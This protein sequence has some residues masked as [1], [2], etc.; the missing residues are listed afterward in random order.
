MRPE[1]LL[2]SIGEIDVK[3][4]TSARRRLEASGDHRSADCK[5]RVCRRT[6][7]CLLI[8]LI[9]SAIVFLLSKS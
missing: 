7:V 3:Y 2:S 9:G 5:R 1:K 4:V 8:V 6:A